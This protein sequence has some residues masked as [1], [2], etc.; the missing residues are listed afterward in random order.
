MAE[1]GITENTPGVFNGQWSAGEGEEYTPI[2]P[3]DGEPIANFRF[4][5]KS[6]YDDAVAKAHEAYKEW[7]TVSMPARGD[8]VNEIGRELTANLDALR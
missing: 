8:I 4:A 2:S 6:Q 5:S 3:F 7:R 1:L